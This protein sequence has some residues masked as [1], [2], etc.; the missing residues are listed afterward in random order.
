MVHIFSLLIA[1]TFPTNP[2]N[3]PLC[4]IEPCYAKC[5]LGTRSIGFP[6][7]LVGETE[8]Q[9]LSYTMES[10]YVS[11]VIYVHVRRHAAL[12]GLFSR[13]SDDFRGSCVCLSVGTASCLPFGS[14][15]E[16]YNLPLHYFKTRGNE[17]SLSS[18]I[19]YKQQGKSNNGSFSII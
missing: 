11:L 14:S 19:L 3:L 17:G 18:I 12:E 9:A 16:Y 2:Q 10:E 6:W 15:G 4:P 8:P 1:L 7:K 5:G 13:F